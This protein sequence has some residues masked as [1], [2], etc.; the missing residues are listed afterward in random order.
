MARPSVSTPEE[1]ERGNAR[2]AAI[3]GS[4]LALSAAVIWGSLGIFA[5]LLYDYAI[6]PI[7]VGAAR[8]VIAAI[9]SLLILS[10]TD[11]ASLR[12]DRKALPF[13]ALFGLVGVALNYLSYFDAIARTSATTAVILLN[14]APIFVAVMAFLMFREPLTWAKGVGLLL[15]LLGCFMVVGGYDAARLVTNARGVLM[16]LSAAVTYASYTILSKHALKSHRSSTTVCYALVF[17]SVFLGLF[18]APHVTQLKG[19]PWRAWLFI[20]A[21]ALGPTLGSY[22]LYV[23]ALSYI[24]ASHESIICMAEPVATGVLAYIILGERMETLQAIGAFAVIAGVTIA[25]WSRRPSAHTRARQN[26]GDPH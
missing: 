24:E 7:V 23:K 10:I 20:V 11:R 6:S 25:Q 2:R 19:L 14:T 9:A 26:H 17:G 3:I 12:I 15:S 8:A 18:A 16:G 4:A 5:V 1:V 13:F 21:L 22:A